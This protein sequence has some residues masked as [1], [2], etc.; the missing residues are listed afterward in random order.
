MRH[1][2]PGL[3]RSLDPR[4]TA[5]SLKYRESFVAILVGDDA[6]PVLRG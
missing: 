4:C 5:F 1:P 6:V 2:V 3:R